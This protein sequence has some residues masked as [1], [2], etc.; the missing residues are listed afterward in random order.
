MTKPLFVG[1]SEFGGAISGFHNH[2]QYGLYAHSQ[3]E[4]RKCSPPESHFAPGLGVPFVASIDSLGT[5]PWD[6]VRGEDE[7]LIV[8]FDFSFSFGFFPPGKRLLAARHPMIV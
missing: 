6:I 5:G 8:L 1:V 2:A 3:H 7:W 4:V